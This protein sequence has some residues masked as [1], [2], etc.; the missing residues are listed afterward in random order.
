MA[1]LN[2]YLN[3]SGDAFNTRCNV[4]LLVGIKIVFSVVNGEW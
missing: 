1:K 2:P 3:F 4:T